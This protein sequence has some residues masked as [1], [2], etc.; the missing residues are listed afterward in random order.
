MVNTHSFITSVTFAHTSLA[1][2][3]DKNHYLYIAMSCNH[4]SNTEPI[5]KPI[6]NTA[7][8]YSWHQTKVI[9]QLPSGEMNKRK[10][11]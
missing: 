11:S 9:P 8:G 7:T 4:K 1:W 6:K 10:E 5:Q 3:V 2:N